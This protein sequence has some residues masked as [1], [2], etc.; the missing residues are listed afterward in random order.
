MEC[1]LV[2]NL[3]T[4]PLNPRKH[5]N[6][7]SIVELANSIKEYGLINPL[8]VRPLENEDDCFEIIC[9]ERRYHALKSIKSEYA[10]CVIVHMND[11]RAREIMLTE[12]IQ[13]EDV[14]PLDEA[15][16]IFELITNYNHSV[17]DLVTKLGKSEFYIRI[18]L[19]LVD[20]CDTLKEEYKNK[21]LSTSLS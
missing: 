1:I 9:G 2:K 10:D 12:N 6:D 21:Y 18:R 19:K 5:I 20:L 17:A 11:I 3:R 4:S 15:E 13:R 14:D 16:S 7:E 8:L